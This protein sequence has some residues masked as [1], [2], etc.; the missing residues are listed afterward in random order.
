MFETAEVGSA[1]SDEA[2]REV[3]GDLRLD[4]VDLQQKCRAADFP[5]III[6]MGVKGAG[7]LDTVNL[8]NTWMDPRWIAT[9]TFDDPTDEEMER[10]VFWRYWR[11]LP[12]AGAI[13]LYP[14]G[15]Y[16]DPI[17][18]HCTGK[19]S[20]AQMDEVILSIKSF[21]R[22]LAEEG[23]MILKFW[24]HLSKPEQRKRFVRHTKDPVVGL[25]ATDSALQAPKDYDKYLEAAG[26]T[27]RQTMDAKAPWFIV[28]GADDN[29]RRATVLMTLRDNL[30]H[31][32]RAK[33]RLLKQR[34]KDRQVAL[35]HGSQ[36]C[37]SIVPVVYGS[38]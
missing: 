29:F 15:W 33:R 35:K 14:G 9:T 38:I 30:K 8:L 1:L 13:G 24:L 27:I 11:S 19:L 36:L 3:R 5:V 20:R 2:F 17:T 34:D 23:A 28:E 32:I 16:M 12:K 26:Y 37:F 31:H 4:L 10:P 6:L 22:T 25:K 18:Q 7:I 21:E